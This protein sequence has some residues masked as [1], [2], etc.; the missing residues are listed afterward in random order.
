MKQLIKIENTNEEYEH[1]YYANGILSHNTICSS[2][3]ILHYLI[4]NYDKNC[5]LSGNVWKTSKEIR[6]KIADIYAELP[7][8]LKPGLLKNNV[9]DMK[10]DNNCRLITATATKRSAIGF[11]IDLL[12]LDEFAH[13]EKNIIDDFYENIFPTVASKTESKVIVT[14]TPNGFNKF[15]DIYHAAE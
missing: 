14:S 3:F 2:I 15:Y 1:S 6:D 11:T 10:F 8:W 5:L 9:V 12:Y 7:F 4:F 13:I